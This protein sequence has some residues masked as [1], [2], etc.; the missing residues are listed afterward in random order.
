MATAFRKHTGKTTTSPALESRSKAVLIIPP[1]SPRSCPNAFNDVKQQQ[2]C[3]PRLHEWVKG[4]LAS[5]AGWTRGRGAVV[6]WS[7]TIQMQMPVLHAQLA[8][9]SP[10]RSVGDGAMWRVVCCRMEA[11][12]AA[13]AAAG[14]QLASAHEV[15]YFFGACQQ[16]CSGQTKYRVSLP[17]TVNNASRQGQ[18]P[19]RN[20]GVPRDLPLWP[21]PPLARPFIR[22]AGRG[23]G[24]P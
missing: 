13:A 17:Q 4:I 18:C 24:A 15:L 9:L 10:W 16:H 21:G 11:W 12:A 1:L 7:L 2:A 14:N 5:R 23:I 22:F 20:G 8:A 19:T 3:G 6:G